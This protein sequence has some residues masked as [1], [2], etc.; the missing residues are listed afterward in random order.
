[1]ISEEFTD[2]PTEEEKTDKDPAVNNQ[3]HAQIE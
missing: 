2:E 1:M 3:V